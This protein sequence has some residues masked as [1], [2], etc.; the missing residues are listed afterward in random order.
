KRRV[1]PAAQSKRN[2][3]HLHLTDD[4]GWRIAIDDPAD[5]PSGIAY[6]LLTRVGGAT[7]MTER[8]TEP[9]T[10]GFY[11]KADYREIVRFAGENGMTVV[12]EI[13]L[14]AHTNS[15]LHS[16][17][18]LN[19]PGA[20]PALQPGQTTVP[21]N[22]TGAVG[23]SSLDAAAAVTYEFT[24]H[25]LTEI[26]ALTPGPYLHIGGD[27]AHV[28]SHA[29]Y[30]K[31][32]EAF[33]GQVADL[34]KTVVGWNEYAGS[35]LPKDRAVVQYWNGDRARVAAAVNDRGA[36]VI[37]SPA[38]TTY[39]PQ[40]QDSRQP[41]GGLWACGT[42]CGLDR[43]YQWDPGAYIPGIQES[44]VLGVESALWGEFIRKPRQAEY[45]AYPR[46]LASAEAGWT[47]QARR[48]FGEFKERLADAGDR[49]AVQGVNFFPTADVPWRVAAR[50]DD[51]KARVGEPVKPGWTVIAPGADGVSATVRWSDGQEQDVTPVTSRAGS[52]PDMWLNG[53]YTAA[54]E[55][56]FSTPGTYTATLTVTVP[57]RDPVESALTVKID[58]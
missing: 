39:L 58:S 48:D 15:A 1:S 23:Y 35:A 19:T 38:S 34:G 22:G 28:T 49:L 18:Q 31:M 7:A 51:V 44:S 42:P 25:V 52:I 14:P 50:G 12:P 5:N 55:R 32:V 17:P 56:T 8:G 37:L 20:R 27:E 54:A 21:H 9:A 47:P 10:T 11:T 26:A 53:P 30:T 16:I 41:Q 43:H 6:G 46:L 29:D 2:R 57:G 33:S 13:D 36:Q 40:K 24:R 45:Y 4:Q 3:L